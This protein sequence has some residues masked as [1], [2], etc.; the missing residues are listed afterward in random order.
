MVNMLL[1][2]SFLSKR[3][4]FSLTRF[5]VGGGLSMA[6]VFE[7]LLGSSSSRTRFLFIPILSSTLFTSAFFNSGLTCG[8]VFFTLRGKTDH[9]ELF[10]LKH[11]WQLVQGQIEDII[12]HEKLKR[13]KYIL[14]SMYYRP[15]IFESFMK[16]MC[17]LKFPV[18][19]Q[20]S[21]NTSYDDLV[22]SEFRTKCFIH[23][24]KFER[25]KISCV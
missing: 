21:M 6:K 12:S 2:I 15:L 3:E 11:L 14:H 16:T 4:I 24:N 1:Y 7:I 18:Q 25:N 17:I 22:S 9:L 13:H 19:A 20:A 23:A 8:Y 10:L 5:S